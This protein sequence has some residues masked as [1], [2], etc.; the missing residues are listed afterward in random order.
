MEEYVKRFKQ[1]DP[2]YVAKHK[3]ILVNEADL[4]EVY[5]YYTKIKRTKFIFINNN[6][7]ESQKRFTCAHELG[8]A[9]L[10]PDEFT[11]KLSKITMLSDMKIENEANEFATHFLIDG[12]H[13]N[14]HINSKY[15]LLDYYGIPYE[16]ER[17][18]N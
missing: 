18:I 4:G 16:M 3:N 1:R 11:P 5:G 12:S 8:H 6:L 10:H 9:M 2:Y 7:N 17:F 14:Y 13:E 15:Q